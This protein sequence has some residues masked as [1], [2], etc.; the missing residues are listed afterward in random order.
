MKRN[1]L[2]FLIVLILLPSFAFADIV[3]FIT[4]E[5]KT[6]LVIESDSD[7]ENIVFVSTSG[8]IKIPR[9]RIS[10][11]TKEPADVSYARIGRGYFDLKDYASAK[12]NLEK[13]LQINPENEDAQKLLADIQE[14]IKREAARNKQERSQKIDQQL[15]T[16]D[17]LLKEEKFDEAQ[18]LLEETERSETSPDQK[19]TIKSFYFR[20]YYKWGLNQLDRLNPKGAAVYFEKALSLQPDNQEVFERLLAIWDKDPNMT[21]KVIAIYEKRAQQNPDDMDLARKLSDLYFRN[22]NPEAAFPYLLKVHQKTLG[23]DAVVAERLRE[24]LSTLHSNAASKKQYPLAAKYYQHLLESFPGEDPTPLYYYQ[25]SEMRQSVSENDF[26]GHINLGNFCK[27]HHLDDDAKS[28]FQYVIARDPANER[29]LKG[30]SEYAF[31]DLGE[32]QRSFEK[33]DFDAALYQ[34][35]Q[36]VNNYMKIPDVLTK[37]YELKEQ[38]ENEIRREQKDKKARAQALASRGNEYYATA[39]SYINNMKSTEVRNDNQIISYKEEAKTFLN[40]AISVWEAALKIDPALARSDTEDLNTKI[41]DAR[42]RLYAL[43]HVVPFPDTYSYRRQ[44]LK[45]SQETK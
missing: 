41:Q 1:H 38:A 25:Y 24:V 16:V 9:S 43:S 35:D 15:Q 23:T 40:R 34:V 42:Q 19:T 31:K 27:D 18:K 22:G 28:E 32:A 5:R 13:A 6:G 12:E 14:E 2:L 45:K 30:L 8:E 10:K 11:I 39:E 3:V 37:A 44:S 17:D 4:G 26:E 7:S 21:E 20:L 36:I 33:R 29:A